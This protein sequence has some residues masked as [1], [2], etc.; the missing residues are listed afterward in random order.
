MDKNRLKWVFFL[1]TVYKDVN[2][3]YRSA[4]HR[5]Y[6]TQLPSPYYGRH[7]V[8]PMSQ[9]SCCTNCITARSITALIFSHTKHKHVPLASEFCPQ[10]F[11]I[12]S[13]RLVVCLWTPLF[14]RHC[15]ALTS[16]VTI[17]PHPAQ[18]GTD[19]DLLLELG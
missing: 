9:Q 17:I 6:L 7:D 16:F 15:S 11:L 4:W 10:G 14:L 18:F 12:R 19:C 1:N 13:L 8:H 5:L 2:S 3:T